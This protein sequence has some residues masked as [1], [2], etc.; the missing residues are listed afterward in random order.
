MI[1]SKMKKLTKEDWYYIRLALRTCLEGDISVWKTN[2][3]I[4]RGLLKKLKG[5]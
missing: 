4:L 1:G 5:E 3:D 2:R